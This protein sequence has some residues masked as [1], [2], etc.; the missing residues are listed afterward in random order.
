MAVLIFDHAEQVQA[1]RVPGI[2]R[3]DFTIHPRSLVQLPRLVVLESF[4]KDAGDSLRRILVQFSI[5]LLRG[6]EW[7]TAHKL[8]RSNAALDDCD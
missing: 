3:Q 8:N 1:I 5:L 2:D 4:C 7:M 6:G